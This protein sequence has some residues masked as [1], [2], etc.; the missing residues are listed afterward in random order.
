VILT[1]LAP[2]ANHLWQSTSCVGAAWLLTLAL[3]K[4]RAAVRYW[5]W[6]AASV[7]FLIPF[8]LI[9]GIGSQMGWRSAPALAQPQFPAVV[10][11]IGGPFAMMAQV[12]PQAAAARETSAISAMLFGV[13]LSGVL[14]GLIFWVRLLRKIRAVRRAATRLDLN[15]PIPV[16]SSAA[17]LEPGVF[18]I[19]KPVLILPE[20]IAERLTPAQLEAVLAHELCHVRRRDNLTAAIHMAV[21]V[22]FWFHPL[23]WWIRRQLV[24]ERERAC[25]EE[26]LGAGN[27]P[28]VYAEGILRICQYYL[29]SRVA[30]VSGISGSDLRKRIETI[31]SNRIANRLN[32]ARWLLLI[33]A[34]AATLAAPL[35]VGA[36]HGQPPPAFEAASVKPTQLGFPDR[37]RIMPGGG[38]DVRD[39]S[40]KGLIEIAYNLQDFQIAGGPKWFDDDRFDIVTTAAGNPSRKQTLLM[41]RTLIAERFRVTLHYDTKE[42]PVYSLG[43]AKNGPKLRSAPS[44]PRPGDGNFGWGRGRIT[45][46][47]VTMAQLCEILSMQ[48]HHMAIDKTGLAGTFDLSLLYTPENYKPIDESNSNPNP[49]EPRPDPNGASVFSAIQEQLGLKL[50]AGKAPVEIL[51]VDHAEKPTAN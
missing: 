2:V 34:G 42:L 35:W 46:Q 6:L 32:L 9:V 50:E 30:C 1:D 48:L 20:G 14:F 24:A 21:E 10:S 25:D 13:W 31:L 8:S 29:E 44:D 40:L 5:L 37:W 39:F 22:V 27:S 33:G 16:W 3:R 41:L 19:R 11:Q 15:L 7:K 47:G 4:N 26:V 49:N 38:L 45:G 51:V 36:I 12:S 17:R 28:D 23:V 43:I 18:G